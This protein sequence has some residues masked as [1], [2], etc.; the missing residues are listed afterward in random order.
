MCPINSVQP[1][2]DEAKKL[3]KH[4]EYLLYA[5]VAISALLL[6]FEP[7]TAIMQF[8]SCF[9]LYTAY[10]TIQYCPCVM[11]LFFS[12]MGALQSLIVLGIQIQNGTL[13][14]MKMKS[15][16]NIILITFF[17]IA[18]YIVFKGYKEFKAISFEGGQPAASLFPNPG[19]CT[20]SFS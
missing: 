6:F 12:A 7:Q 1:P 18:F 16:V 9:L 13:L 17:P 5:H 20:C 19:M 2:T 15:T 4:M 10:K 14:P 11:Y 3:V 8:L